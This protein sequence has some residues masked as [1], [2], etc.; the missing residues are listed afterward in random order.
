MTPLRLAL[1]AFAA[2]AVGCA[3]AGGQY[4]TART[5]GTAKTWGSGRTIEPGPPFRGA[6]YRELALPNGDLGGQA[7]FSRDGKRLAV[8]SWAGVTVFATDTGKPVGGTALPV[9]AGY[10][11]SVRMAFTA[12][13]TVL[14]AS[15]GSDAAVQFRDVAT[16]AAV[17]DWR[18]PDPRSDDPA[19]LLALAPTADRIFV[20]GKAGGDGHPV[21][22]PTKSAAVAT[23]GPWD[24][25]ADAA[26]APDGSTLAVRSAGGQL[27]LVNPTTGKL[28]WEVPSAAPVPEREI[29]FATGGAYLLVPGAGHTAV[30]STADGKEWAR[31][32][33]DGDPP[34]MAADGRLLVAHVRGAL[35]QYDLWAGREVRGYDP[36]HDHCAG[37]VAS[38]DGKTL[39]VIGVGAGGRLA[40][41]LTPFPTLPPPI[42]PRADLSRQQVGDYWAALA[43]P[44]LFHRRYAVSVF[45]ARPEQ[46]MTVAPARL[47]PVPDR[48]RLL[49]E[50]LVKNLA[51]PDPTFRDRVAAE[52]DHYTVKFRPLLT[53]ARDAAGP[54]PVRDKL[55]AALAKANGQLPEA[56]AVEVLEGIGTPEAR[57]LLTALAGGAK[58]AAVTEHAVASMKR[59]ERKK[60]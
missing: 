6:A 1:F 23:V 9:K 50:D 4:G 10:R 55:T 33:F 53:A 39:A 58:G 54:G 60:P 8:P 17:R 26:F 43:S 49:V 36:P 19:T 12:D 57:T 27:R 20:R 32:P 48:D 52:L 56:G 14:A 29:S 35:R 34:A 22:D 13:G 28:V 46:T 38:P 59:L 21:Y 15:V 25:V 44:N 40:V 47:S 24:A 30:V 3:P 42:H 51:D 7:V 18:P 41:Y 5:Y 2:F 45:V 31:V 11:R 16:Q 37:A